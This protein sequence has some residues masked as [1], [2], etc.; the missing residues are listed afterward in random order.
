MLLELSSH[1]PKG[2][3]KMWGRPGGGAGQ[4]KNGSEL[5]NICS[6]GRVPKCLLQYAL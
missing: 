3:G 4:D 5:I 6:L 2:E 1:F